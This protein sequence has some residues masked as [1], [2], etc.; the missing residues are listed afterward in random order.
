MTA[1]I[2][3]RLTAATRGRQR[4]GARRN[5]PA[6]R[7]RAGFG[8]PNS[9]RAARDCMCCDSAWMS[10]KRRSN[11]ALEDRGRPGPCRS[12]ATA[13][14]A[15]RIACRGQPQRAAPAAA[16]LST[17][18]PDLVS[19]SIRRPRRAEPPRPRP[20]RPAPSIVPPVVPR[21]RGFCGWPGPRSRRAG[22]RDA[23]RHAGDTH[24]VQAL[25]RKRIQPARFAAER[26]ILRVLLNASGT[27]TSSSR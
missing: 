26:R 6:G 7:S 13:S 15:S 23:Q 1:S 5:S 25:H 9:K 20:T 16:P 22:T 11:G 4:P 14:I 3:G 2:F 18:R 12:S 27:K 19:V 21:S 8:R 17:R 24:G 10:R